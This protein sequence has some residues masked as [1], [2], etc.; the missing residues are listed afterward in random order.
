M[1]ARR[2]VGVPASG[3]RKCPRCKGHGQFDE[4]APNG[5]L[6]QCDRCD[7]AGVIAEPKPPKDSQ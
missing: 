6:K 7:G 2:Y 5:R 4:R 3:E 1:S